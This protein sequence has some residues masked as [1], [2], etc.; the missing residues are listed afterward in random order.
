VTLLAIGLAALGL[1][2]RWRA[3]RTA[4]DGS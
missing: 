3:R 2:A 4:R 1:V